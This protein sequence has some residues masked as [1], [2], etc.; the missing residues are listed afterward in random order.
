MYV[1]FPRKDE[2]INLIMVS[3]PTTCVRVYL[4]M[5]DADVH[6]CKRVTGGSG[7]NVERI[8]QLPFYCE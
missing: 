2:P 1:Q 7:Q 5:W 8:Q 3:N 4:S 6:A